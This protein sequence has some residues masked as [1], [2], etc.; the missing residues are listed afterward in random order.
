VAATGLG[1]DSNVILVASMLISPLMVTIILN[2]MLYH[3]AE[4]QV[5]EHNFMMM[6]LVKHGESFVILQL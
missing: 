2:A 6:C 4:V 5:M 1:E 3:V